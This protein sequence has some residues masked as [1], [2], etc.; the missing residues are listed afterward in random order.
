MILVRLLAVATTEVEKQVYNK[1]S[2]PP[3]VAICIVIACILVLALPLQKKMTTS[4][5]VVR[6]QGFCARQH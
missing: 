1:L 6:F 4:N 3:V 5:I 2:F